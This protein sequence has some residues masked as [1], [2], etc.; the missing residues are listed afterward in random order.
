MCTLAIF[1]LYRLK[2]AEGRPLFKSLSSLDIQRLT[3]PVTSYSPCIS[4]METHP[5]MKKT[6]PKRPRESELKRQDSS[7]FCNSDVESSPIFQTPPHTPPS[8]KRTKIVKRQEIETPILRSLEHEF[9]FDDDE[10]F[11]RFGSRKRKQTEFLGVEQV[12]EETNIK[13]R[14]S[15]RKLQFSPPSSIREPKKDSSCQSSELKK[16]SSSQE[17]DGMQSP[18][19][20]ETISV[21]Q[22][23]EES[24]LGSKTQEMVS[25]ANLTP[26]TYY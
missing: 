10:S 3:N 23:A 6:V 9:G 16:E 5:R 14:S 12:E 7:M 18:V 1:L 25:V 19:I 26:P 24:D 8:E 11:R 22:K 15:G 17:S 21:E 20:A 4:S 13:R 2:A